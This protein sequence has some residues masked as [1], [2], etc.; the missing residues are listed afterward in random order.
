MINRKTNRF[1]L[2]DNECEKLNNVESKYLNET[3]ATEKDLTNAGL[4]A[5][6]KC[7]KN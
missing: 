7:I 2:K 3:T 6:E 4:K 1:H 5:C